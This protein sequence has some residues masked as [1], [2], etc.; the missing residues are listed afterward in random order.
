M[1]WSKGCVKTV[2]DGLL[3][4]AV[5]TITRLEPGGD[6]SSLRPRALWHSGPI[7]L[8]RTASSFPP[9]IGLLLP[10]ADS[11]SA[12]SWLYPLCQEPRGIDRDLAKTPGKGTAP[13]RALCAAFLSIAG[14]IRCCLLL[15]TRAIAGQ[16]L[17]EKQSKVKGNRSPELNRGFSKTFA[18][19]VVSVSLT[20]SDL[21]KAENQSI[22]LSTDIIS[23]R[24]GT[25]R[26]L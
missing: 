16:I 21:A 9:W 14:H 2:V 7:R 12:P 20:L 11:S 22:A 13:Q 1:C 23:Q 17:N 3:S 26:P 18:L 6:W 19:H 8:E 10:E 4:S 15:E 25:H 5:S 24:L